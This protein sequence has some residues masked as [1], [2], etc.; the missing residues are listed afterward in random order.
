MKLSKYAYTQIKEMIKSGKYRPGD[1][2]PEAEL[3]DILKISR[4]PLRQALQK[5]QVERI[6]KIR[7][8]HGAF[9]ATLDI[10][11]L[12]NIY[13]SREAIE[14]MLIN[15]NCRA[16]VPVEEYVELKKSIETL[17]NQPD[18]IKKYDELSETGTRLI[19]LIKKNAENPILERMSDMIT[20]QL[21]TLVHVT[22]TIPRFPDESAPEHIQI[23][24]AII[25]KNGPQAEAI[26][27]THIKN[28]FT[29]I[30]NMLQS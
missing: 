1:P 16:R 21:N 15:L 7:T 9:V 20:E 6:V 5:L 24:D 29:R 13:E 23:L 11:D 14:G 17:V 18:S 25:K 22:R 10:K 8:M 27:R 28:T 19:F 3:C 4:T 12:C 26:A 30:L 2:L